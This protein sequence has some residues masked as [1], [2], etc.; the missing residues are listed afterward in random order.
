MKAGKLSNY[1]YV[2]S[3]ALS[4][5]NCL[6]AVQDFF[7]KGECWAKV[8]PFFEVGNDERFLDRKI[9]NVRTYKIVT[10]F[11][12][13]FDFSPSDIIVFNDKIL[14]VQGISNKDEGDY[15]ISVNAIEI[16]ED[17]INLVPSGMFNQEGEPMYNQEGEPMYNQ[18]G[19]A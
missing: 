9:T 12:I 7:P 3:Q 18:E 2:Y 16:Q 1:I 13:G 8:S 5:V 10:R 14:R 6:G 17:E 15:S 11:N 4:Q 19:V